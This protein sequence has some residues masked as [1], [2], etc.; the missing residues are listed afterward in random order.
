[1]IPIPLAPGAQP[2][3]DPEQISSKPIFLTHRNY[4]IANVC[5]FKPLHLRLVCCQQQIANTVADMSLI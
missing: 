4:E 5:C 2:V 3:R 1:M